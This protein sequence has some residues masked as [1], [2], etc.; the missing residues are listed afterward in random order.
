MEAQSMA[1]DVTK[2]R[3]ITLGEAAAMLPARRGGR[4]VHVSTLFRWAQKGC[5]GVRLEVVRIGSALHT[6]REAMARFCHRLTEAHPIPAPAEVATPAS[7]R[8][9]HA[10]AEKE[11]K[12]LGI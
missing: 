9:A 8:E 11:A 1:I 10:N 2:E 7:R 5:R 12:A 4:K 3:I 6:S